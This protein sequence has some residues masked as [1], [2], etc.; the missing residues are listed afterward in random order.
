M[1][2]GR[3]QRLQVEVLCCAVTETKTH[4][5][6]MGTRLRSRKQ[7]RT[8][9]AAYIHSH[10]GVHRAILAPPA[11]EMLLLLGLGVSFGGNRIPILPELIIGALMAHASLRGLA[12][13]IVDITAGLA[14]GFFCVSLRSTGHHSGVLG[15]S[16]QFF[17]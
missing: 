9:L 1:K 15:Y 14:S 17:G 10:R 2:Y 6:P 7:N 5:R 3:R 11:L 13:R 16:F 8:F 4:A 12:L